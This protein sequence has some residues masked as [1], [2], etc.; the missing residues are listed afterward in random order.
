MLCVYRCQLPSAADMA[1]EQRWTQRIRRRTSAGAVDMPQTSRK[2]RLR[3]SAVQCR[4]QKTSHC[5][6]SLASNV[7]C[8]MFA[9]CRLCRLL[10]AVSAFRCLLSLPSTVY[11]LPSTV[12]RLSS[13]VY[14]LLSA[15]YR[16][17]FPRPVRRTNSGQCPLAQA[18]RQRTAADGEICDSSA[19]TETSLPSPADAA[20]PRGLLE[21]RKSRHTGQDRLPRA[22]QNRGPLNH[23]SVTHM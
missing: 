1:Q 12:C 16:L 19:N 22:T 11:R 20:A 3:E 6:L 2:K 21:T 15:V 23:Q 13:I 18:G 9:I 8:L 17:P 4:R 14:R 5:E 10:S 7:C